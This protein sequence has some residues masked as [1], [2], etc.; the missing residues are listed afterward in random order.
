LRTQQALAKL[1]PP[2]KAE[3][4]PKPKVETEVE[5][6]DAGSDGG[7]VRTVSLDLLNSVLNDTFSSSACLVRNGRQTTPRTKKAIITST[8]VVIVTIAI[9]TAMEGCPGIWRT[10][11]KMKCLNVFTNDLASCSGL[12]SLACFYDLL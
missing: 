3:L 1:L 7:D 9:H 5:G 6:E 11:T 8:A 4:T 10:R 2:K 12:A